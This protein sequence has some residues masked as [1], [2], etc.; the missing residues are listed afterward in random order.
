M[1][2]T[3]PLAGASGVMKRDVVVGEIAHAAGMAVSN[4]R[5]LNS[6]GLI[7]RRDA[8]LGIIRRLRATMGE[9][10]MGFKAPINAVGWQASS[11]GKRTPDREGQQSN[12]SYILLPH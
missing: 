10:V 8:C 3:A 7:R 11:M 2:I 12:R 6:I 5:A 4:A 1:V 9:C